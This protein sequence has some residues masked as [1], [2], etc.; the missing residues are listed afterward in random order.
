MSQ[1]GFCI[2]HCYCFQTEI[3]SRTNEKLLELLCALL[4]CF[5]IRF[6]LHERIGTF[7]CGRDATLVWC[8]LNNSD[9]LTGTCLDIR[10]PKRRGKFVLSSAEEAQLQQLIRVQSTPQGLR[11]ERESYRRSSSTR[12]C[13]IAMA[14][15]FAPTLISRRSCSVGKWDR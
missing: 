1:L 6:T 9:I 7:A 12:F 5:L 11:R 13:W 15:W 2:H 10:M 14:A 3:A 8:L 4:K